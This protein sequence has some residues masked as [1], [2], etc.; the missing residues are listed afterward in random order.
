MRA[1]TARALA[2]G[3][4]ALVTISP[5]RA[6]DS[7]VAKLPQLAAD[8]SQTSVSGISSGAYMAG[9]F[10]IAHSKIVTGAAIIAGGPYGCAESAFADIMPGPGATILNLSKA[11][12]GC[13]LNALALWGVPDVDQLVRKTEKLADAGRIDPIADLKNDRI[14]LFSGTND[15]TVVP[16]IVTAAFDYYKRMGVPEKNITYVSDMPAGHAFVTEADGLACENTGN[17]YVVDCDYDQAGGV[18]KQIYGDLA[19]RSATPA[20][21]FTEFDQGPFLNGEGN[22]GMEPTGVVYAPP[23]CVKG[24]TCRVHIAYHGCGQN[25]SSTGDAFIKESGYANWADA[26]RLVILFPQASVSAVN[27]QGCWDWWGYT[28]ANYLTRDAAQ[29]RVVYKMLE[30]LA[31]PRS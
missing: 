29:I 9:Q 18:L 24:E 26:N 12:N 15:R 14:Y 1:V 11:V 20:G 2:I 16:A 30:T 8:I 25:R 4:L 19:P 10:Q 27:P 21:T 13:M 22:T 3:A 5:S 7:S 6:G 17:P 23:A 28:G 31:K